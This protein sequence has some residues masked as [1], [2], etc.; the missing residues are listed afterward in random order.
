MVGVRRMLRLRQMN[1]AGRDGDSDSGRAGLRSPGTA[2]PVLITSILDFLHW[3]PSLSSILFDITVATK[4]HP[5]HVYWRKKGLV[6]RT[7]L[8]SIL[9]ASLCCSVP[10][11]ALGYRSLPSNGI[12]LVHGM[13]LMMGGGFSRSVNKRKAPTL[14]PQAEKHLK[15]ANGVLEIAQARFFHDSIQ[16]LRLNSPD[17][18]I[19][20]ENHKEMLK[21]GKLELS[22]HQKLV[23]MTWD[24]M[25]AYLPIISQNIDTASQAKVEKR[26]KLIA[27]AVC[28]ENNDGSAPRVLDV[29]CGNGATFPFI[30]K[31]GASKSG[32]L[33]ID[34]SSLMIDAARSAYPDI[35]F[36]RGDFLES[37]ITAQ[38]SA[39]DTVLFNGSLQFFPDVPAALSRAARCLRPGG[40]I[41]IA[42]ANGAAFVSAERRGN[43]ATVV[44]DMPDLEEL[45]RLARALG[46]ELVPPAQLGWR[47]PAGLDAFY[48]AA[49]DLGPA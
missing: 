33:G 11:S 29:G 47:D 4:R 3:R 49:L 42:H 18:Y 23:E 39:F 6:H 12:R 27:K 32:Y 7:M 28:I 34:L 36:Q 46:A 35:R 45:G 38:P 2:G 22:A 9:V 8:R 26:L 21:Q 37:P 10:L 40:R 20:I 41:V 31:A 48:L 25:A 19:K 16:S 15:D 44:S 17:M 1:S 5:R 14:D 13:N 24:T 43:P 30:I